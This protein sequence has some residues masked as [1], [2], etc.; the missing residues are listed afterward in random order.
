MQDGISQW[1][2][3]P[4]LLDLREKYGV[5]IVPLANSSGVAPSII[6]CMLLGR[7]VERVN[8]ISV[9]NGLK[10]LIGVDYSLGDVD[11]PLL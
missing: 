2:K 9:L 11:V 7:P 5:A 3:K 6:Y 4:T 10:D 8:A 1:E